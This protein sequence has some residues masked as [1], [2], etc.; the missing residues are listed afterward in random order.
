[1]VKHEQGLRQEL[2]DAASD[3]KETRPARAGTGREDPGL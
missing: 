3:G 1:M 2:H